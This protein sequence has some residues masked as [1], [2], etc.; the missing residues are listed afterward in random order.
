M[1]SWLTAGLSGTTAIN[2]YKRPLDSRTR[3]TTQLYEYEIWLTMLSSIFK[4]I[5]NPESFIVLLN[6]Q[7]N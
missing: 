4:K 6:N 3:M 2:D 1:N 7:K 5:D